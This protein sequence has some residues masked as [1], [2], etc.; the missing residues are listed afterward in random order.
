MFRKF[1]IVYL[2]VLF[3]QIVLCQQGWYKLSSGT[4]HN[5]RSL[6]TDA[7]T[8]YAVGYNGTIV[9]T[10]DGGL[11]WTSQQIATSEHLHSVHFLAQSTIGYVVGGTNIS[12]ILE[13]QM[14]GRTGKVSP[15]L[16]HSD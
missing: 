7:N 10:T 12:V 6:F 9:K 2:T 15:L 8:G 4:S 14:A 13:P 16:E 11:N 1:L 3:S 5:L